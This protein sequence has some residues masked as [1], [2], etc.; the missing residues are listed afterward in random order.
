MA[1]G[2]RARGWDYR[3]RTSRLFPPAAHQ[4]PGL[5]AGVLAVFED[6]DA[7][8]QGRLVA[9][10]PLH[11]ALAA[12]GEIVGDFG[13]VQPQPLEGDHIDVRALAGLGPGPTLETGG[14]GR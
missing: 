9:L 12:G 2:R 7:G 4:P 6:R 11:E 10:D 3:A 5:G 13:G 14:I 8:D 1:P